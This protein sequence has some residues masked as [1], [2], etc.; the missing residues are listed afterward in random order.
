M[1]IKVKH[2]GNGKASEVIVRRWKKRYDGNG[3]SVR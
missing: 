1:K 2:V 3:G